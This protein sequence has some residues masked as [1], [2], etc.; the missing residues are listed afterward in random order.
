MGAGR[1]QSISFFASAPDEDDPARRQVSRLWRFRL[2]I[3]FPQP[4]GLG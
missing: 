4:F 1:L 2:F 3:S